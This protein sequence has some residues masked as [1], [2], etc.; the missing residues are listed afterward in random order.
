MILVL[1][2]GLIGWGLGSAVTS[3]GASAGFWNSLYLSGSTFFTLGLGDLRPDSTFSRVIT[4][5]EAGAGFGFLALVITYLPVLYQAFSR[6][7]LN[8]SLLDARA[9]SPPSAGEYFRRLGT[10]NDVESL[11]DLLQEWER[12]AAELLE[13][14]LSYPVLMLYRS[15]H[16]RQ[17][18]LSAL[19]LILDV[20]ALVL[21]GGVKG[22]QQRARLTF[23]MA[24][25]AAVDLS[26]VLLTAP[27]PN[28]D[29]LSEDAFGR[30]VGTGGS[31]LRTVR[32]EELADLRANYEPYLAALSRLLLMPL[33]PWLPSDTQ[34]AWQS[35]P[36]SP[37]E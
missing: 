8:V 15:Q 24:R 32:W 23:A 28:V 37:P 3:T 16:E 2:F 34:D 30:L 31:L 7:E 22:A 6:R 19:T 14:H 29:R 5:I 21:A 25:H 35:S 10:T 13:I 27:S 11:N 18:W 20:S 17:S 12:L 36:S 9:G 1:G 4:V 26:Q 33:P